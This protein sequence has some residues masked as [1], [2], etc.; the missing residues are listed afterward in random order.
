MSGQVRPLGFFAGAVRAWDRFWF[1]PAD[2]TTLGLMRICCGLMLLYVHL[3]YTFDLQTFFGRH[4]W[5]DLQAANEFRHDFPG[6]APPSVWGQN[7]PVQPKDDADAAY[8]QKWGVTNEQVYDKGQ[9]RWSI[10]Y[11]VTD[12]AWMMVVHGCFLLVM[13]LFTIG[14]CTPVT[15]VLSWIAVLSYIHRAP[16][17]LFG[18][19]AMMNLGVLY[20]A[21][22]PSG[23]ALSVDRLIRKFVARRRA[24]REDRSVP[25]FGAPAPQISANF[26]L[27][28]LQINVCLVYFISGLSKLKGDFWLSGNACWLVMVNNEFSPVHSP[29]YMAG[30]R[31]ICQYRWLWELVVTSLTYFTLAFEI[32]FIYL[33]WNRRLRWTMIAAAVLLHLGIA[34]CMGLVT[35]SMMMLVLVLSTVPGP[36]VRSLLNRIS[37]RT[38]SVELDALT[39]NGQGAKMES[40][41]AGSLGAPTRI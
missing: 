36:A 37:G 10:W 2:P 30:I 20:L 40:K 31:L 41:M 11:H 19:D 34:I 24:L 21:L 7:E 32:S 12:P 14:L 5:F 35:F 1:R 9:Y 27:R 39:L 8:R 15:G 17:V 6:A 13:V 38:Q 29:L 33:I 3:A 4:A 22:G 25:V 23:A 16:T 18:V 26:A 28:L